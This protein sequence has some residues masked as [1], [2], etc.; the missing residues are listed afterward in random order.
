VLTWFVQQTYIFQ[1]M[2]IYTGMS[3]KTKI[4][5]ILRT[6]HNVIQEIKIIRT[7]WTVSYV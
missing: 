1:V 2:K 5:D 3:A 7:T 6:R 4:L